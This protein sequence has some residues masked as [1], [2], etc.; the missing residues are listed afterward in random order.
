MKLPLRPLET[1]P[2]EP[3]SLLAAGDSQG[4]LDCCARDVDAAAEVGR[5]SDQYYQ[6]IVARGELQLKLA[7]FS[8]AFADGKYA[9]ELDAKNA[10]GW[11]LCAQARWNMAEFRDAI[12]DCDQ[13]SRIVPERCLCARSA[14]RLARSDGSLTRP[15]I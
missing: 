2:T 14:W 12:T 7:A 4:A 6:S 1:G 9:I 8:L 5:D 13:V 3:E 15:F 10:V 11:Y